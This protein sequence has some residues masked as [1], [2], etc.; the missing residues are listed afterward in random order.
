MGVSACTA[1][2]RRMCA[3]LLGLDVG[4]ALAGEGGPPP[5]DPEQVKAGRQIYQQYC[6]S[7][8]G[9][10]G[11]VTANWE[12]PDTQGELPPPPHDAEGHTWKHADAVLYRKIGRAHV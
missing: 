5:L 1:R 3:V 12:E 10:R 4:G 11:E 7:C 8:H 2:R 6:A 9:P